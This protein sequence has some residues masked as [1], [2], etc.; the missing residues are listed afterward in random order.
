MRTYRIYQLDIEGNRTAIVGRAILPE[1]KTTRGFAVAFSSW[2]TRNRRQDEGSVG[3]EAVALD[4]KD[5]LESVALETAAVED[6]ASILDLGEIDNV[7]AELAGARSLVDLVDL[8]ADRIAELDTPA[9]WDSEVYLLLD[10]L[11]GR[12]TKEAFEQFLRY[13]QADIT[14]RL[15]SGMW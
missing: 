15:A 12:A 10:A 3:Y 11:E 2:V 5:G 9:R 14:R 8:L 6:P 4:A 7:A 13:L 1:D